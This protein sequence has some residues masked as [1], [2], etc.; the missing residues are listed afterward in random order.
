MGTSQEYSSAPSPALE[1]TS[2]MSFF[3]RALNAIGTEIFLLLRKM[4]IVQMMD[5]LA[6][7]EYPN[8]RSISEIERDAALC[9][10]NIDFATARVRTLPRTIIPVGAMH[11]RPSKPLPK[12]RK[13][14]RFL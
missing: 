8:A 3:Q 5:D 9:L 10:A 14:N 11:V 12:V 2:Q 7:K 13:L 1:F 4:F 6:R